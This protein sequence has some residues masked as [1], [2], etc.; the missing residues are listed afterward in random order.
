[1]ADVVDVKR[2]CSAGPAVEETACA[3]LTS[4]SLNC[5]CRSKGHTDASPRCW[6]RHGA[7][8]A[9]L[10]TKSNRTRLPSIDRAVSPTQAPDRLLGGRRSRTLKQL[11][12][13][14]G[15]VASAME[16]AW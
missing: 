3:T 15:S 12:A 4:D 13:H 5:G 9:V 7:I 1:M 6:L 11:W 2:S 14:G 10:P 16:G 8:A